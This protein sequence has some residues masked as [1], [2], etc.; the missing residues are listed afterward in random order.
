MDRYYA[1][2]SKNIWIFVPG[3]PV[4]QNKHNISKMF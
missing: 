4:C 2:F 3:N 1:V